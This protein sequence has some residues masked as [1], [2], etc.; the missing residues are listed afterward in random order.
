MAKFALLGGSLKHTMSPPIHDRLFTL[1]GRTASYEIIELSEKELSENS[2][3]LR[4]LDG[5]NITIPHKIGII[6]YC[7][8]L[9]ESAKRY[10]SVNCIDNKN[11]VHTGY[12]TDCDGFL[13]T[14]SA[15][16]ANVFPAVTVWI[17]PR[18]GQPTACGGVA[19]YNTYSGRFCA[20]DADFFYVVVKNPF[21]QLVGGGGRP[22][23]FFILRADQSNTFGSL[24]EFAVMPN[25]AATAILHIQHTIVKIMHH[26][27]EERSNSVFNVS[28]KR[29]RADVDFMALFFTVDCPDRVNRVVT[30]CT[31]RALNSDDRHFKLSIEK[32]F[33]E[34]TKGALQRAKHA[35]ALILNLH[36]TSPFF[37]SKLNLTKERDFVILVP[38]PLL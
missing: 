14:V 32:V 8:E 28:V 21:D 7:D 24:F 20:V 6:D 31:G 2:D 18:E 27:V 16:G 34:Q 26:L 12:N 15:M 36:N 1:R 38:V 33:V 11:G 23:A 10:H 25:A 30:V 35:R 17:A 4:S 3:R 9:A 22:S 13:R 29:P 5:L 37:E 19:A